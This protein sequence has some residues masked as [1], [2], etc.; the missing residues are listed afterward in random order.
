MF[1]KVI[2]FNVLSILSAAFAALLLSIAIPGAVIYAFAQMHCDY[3]NN[4]YM[5]DRVSDL[6]RL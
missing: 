4:C 6:T 3:S 2:T 5:T 1:S